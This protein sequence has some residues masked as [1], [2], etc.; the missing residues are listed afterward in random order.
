LCKN[1]RKKARLLKIS[2]NSSLVRSAPNKFLL[3]R[4]S[5]LWSR[6]TALGLHQLS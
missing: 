5:V 6:N 2:L 4:T 1:H 3:R